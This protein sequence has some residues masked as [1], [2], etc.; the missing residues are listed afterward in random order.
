MVKVM[1][2]FTPLR[3]KLSRRT[4]VQLYVEVSNDEAENKM[5]SLYINLSKDISFEKGGFKTD[6]VER[7]SSL[8]PGETKRFYY[9]LHPKPHLNYGEHNVKVTLLDHYISFDNVKNEKIRNMSLMV[10]E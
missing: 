2:N 7:L 1:S 4:P 10:E 6:T 5:V 8:K 9:E 3:M